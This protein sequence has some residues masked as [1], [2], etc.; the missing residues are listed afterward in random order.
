M[1]KA[2]VFGLLAAV[3]V[4]VSSHIFPS[5]T[6]E[7][8]RLPSLTKK[9]RMDLAMEQEYEMTHDPAT[10]EIP[11]EAL[12]EAYLYAERLR[13]QQ[14]ISRGAI[15][16]M[17]WTER[18]PNN[19]GGRTRT[20]MVDPNDSTKRTVWAAG[21][22]GGLWKTTDIS[23]NPPNWQNIDDFFGNLAITSL[24]HDP[25][26]TQVMY[27][28][29]GEGYYNS[30]AM[31]G[32]GIW[33]STDGG[34]TWN[35]LPSTQNGTYYYCYRLL[36]VGQDT[37]LAATR[38]GLRRSTNGGVSWTK[39]LG[40]SGV[41]N[42]IYDI[43]MAADGR[44]FATPNGGIHI[45]SDRGATFGAA[46]TLPVSTERIE[47][48][49]ALSDAN[50]VYA[51]VERNNRVEAILRSTNGGASWSTMS[52]PND[53]DGGIPATDFSRGQAWYD[54]TIAVDPNNRDVLLVGGIDLFRS[55]NGGSSWQQISHWWG[56][57]GFQEVHADQHFIYFQ[58]GSSDVIYFGNDGGVYVTY[59]GNNN[60]PNIQRKDAGYRTIQF[61]A[62]AIHPNSGVDH[63]LAGSQDNGS[64]RFNAPGLGNTLEV[65]GGDGAFCHIDQNQPQ[66][67]I[68]SYVYNNYFRSTN[69]G[70]SFTSSRHGNTGRFINPTDY[71]D[72][73]NKLY[74]ARNNGQYLRWD[75]PQSG[76]SFATVTAGFGS[77]VS[78]VTCDPNA[79]N[80]VYFG[81]GNG[82]VY[83]V[84]NA[85]TNS[86]G[87]VHINN[88]AGMPGGYISSIAVDDGNSSHLLVTYSSY[89]VNSVWE[90]SNGGGSWQ[91]VEGNLPN[92]PV[93]WA[94]FNPL[95][96]DQALLGTELGVWSTD[97]LDGNNTD[98]GP[99]STGLANTRV[100]M[101]QV[102]SSDRLMIASTHGRGLF[103]SDVFM[104]P[105]A[106]LGA[107]SRISYVDKTI[108]FTD[109]S[110]KATSWAWDF[111]DG[112]TSTSQHPSH[113]YNAPGLYT[114]TLSINGGADADIQTD[115]IHILPDRPTPYAA[116]DGG[117]FETNVLDFAPEAISGTPFERGSSAVNGKQG[118]FGGSNAWV[119]GLSQNNYTDLTD[120]RLYTP[121]YDFSL[122]GVY[123]LR[124]R[125]RFYTEANY[126][127]FRIEYSLDEGDS[128]TPLGINGTQV[129][130]YNFANTAWTTSFP[131]NE[132]YFAGNRSN[133]FNEYFYDVTFLS[134]NP[135][136]A[137][138]FRFKTDGYVTAPGVAIDNF[139]IDNYLLTANLLGFEGKWENRAALLQWVAE[140]DGSSEYFNLER[141]SSGNDFEEVA[142][143]PFVSGD[144]VSTYE[145]LDK[146]ASVGLNYYRLKWQDVNGATAF[147]NTI[148]LTRPENGFSLYPNPA[149][150]FVNIQLDFDAEVK[151]I[152]MKGQVARQMSLNSGTHRIALQDLP[153]G[154]YIAEIMTVDGG[155]YGGK[156]VVR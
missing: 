10:G 73:A 9:D 56:G 101:L 126:D 80:R 26:N 92:I 111:G 28:G 52:E 33:K 86:P 119:T 118:T 84:D 110:V 32:L 68:T 57:Y 42:R 109:Y 91:S 103:S 112:N 31:R 105:D 27:F 142:Q 95:D 156:V 150:D 115:Y 49:C 64:H 19:F 25:V 146:E 63:F 70:N 23:A 58:P 18:G 55:S 138:R 135:N 134:G 34:A 1:K 24:V 93:R 124:F 117:S 121:N 78:A 72:D 114:V 137:F 36:M 151:L 29:T 122:L 132:A 47:I 16:D 77:K 89:G 60:I 53:A 125:S 61:Y 15:P 66:Y 45:S 94:I 97:D 141:S 108:Q 44:I 148:T 65:T 104:D 74:G 145:F 113:T 37:I 13:A 106:K 71:D 90:T 131:I 116:A 5:Q 143:I 136:V 41:S 46:L 140:T 144:V 76:S 130:W 85:H 43:E 38:S 88:G 54:L 20:I 39:V 99:S 35:P 152:D 59:N 21:V 2:Y 155:K 51:L 11:K 50:Y 14:D 79:A 62:C 87:V 139:E 129:N 81:I 3:I 67:Q 7:E 17:N 147:S 123:T 48:G 40:G 153:K 6:A 98:W 133:A 12:R 4:L 128:W 75:N 22:A 82:R 83:R 154:I 107:D 8:Q 96:S 100:D 120:A 69:G 102:R 127:G 30:D 149:T